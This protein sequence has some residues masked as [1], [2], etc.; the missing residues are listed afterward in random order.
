MIS[1]NAH[2]KTL[3]TLL[4]LSAWLYFGISHGPLVFILPAIALLGLII[5]GL[6]YTYF[7]GR[8]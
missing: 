6:L 3:A 7:S 2:L 4:L 8:D 1:Y 5:Y